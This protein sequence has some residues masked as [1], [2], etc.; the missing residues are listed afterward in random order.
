MSGKRT[1]MGRAAWATI[2]AFLFASLGACT[3]AQDGAPPPARPPGPAAPEVETGIPPAATF[4]SLAHLIETAQGDGRGPFQAPSAAEQGAFAA[5]VE[6]MARASTATATP[7][8]LIAR[9]L[10]AALAARAPAWNAQLQRLG[11]ELVIAEEREPLLLIREL[12]GI[13]RGGGVYVLRPH[14]PRPALVFEAPHCF[15]DGG[16]GPIAR[17]LFERTGAAALAMNTVHR[18]LGKEKPPANGVSPADVAHSERSAFQGFTVGASRALA[19]AAFVQI[20]GFAPEAHPE[21]AGVDVVASKGEAAPVADPAFE[22]LV[23]RLRALLG[24]KQV[25]V[26][27]REARTLGATENVQGRFLNAYSDDRF[28]HLELSRGLRARLD[29]EAGLAEKLADALA[30]LVEAGR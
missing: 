12:E 3:R 26:F 1:F 6:E 8:E 5:L 30:P 2:F 15:F 19:R 25:A 7:A 22:G 11:F 24:A 14:A 27:G 21:L 20:H 16:T 23:P 10:P 29:R 17:D 18:Y 4:D 13:R 28:Y 9:D